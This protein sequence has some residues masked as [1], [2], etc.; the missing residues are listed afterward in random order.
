MHLILVSAQYDSCGTA[1]PYPHISS[2][3]CRA[4]SD[5]GIVP[6]LASCAPAEAQA[7]CTD[8]LLLTGG[9]DLTPEYYPY[10][11]PPETLSF[12]GRP[13]DYYEIA[14]LRAFLAREKPVFGIC[15]GMQLINVLLGGTLWED[16]A[17]ELGNR[18]HTGGQMHEIRIGPDSWL[19][20]R[21]GAQAVVN[22]YH[23]QACRE[24]AP[25]LTETARAPDGTTEA[26]CHESLPVYG[27][28]WHPERMFVPE[29]CDSG[30]MRRLFAF[31]CE[32]VQKHA[33]T[34]KTGT[35]FFEIPALQSNSGMV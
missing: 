9:G 1:M 13:R 21:F 5:V 30:G 7:A 23:H 24:L 12:S 17:L 6:V 32:I 14:L 3:Y 20:S 33:K 34:R 26:F 10:H 25:G 35:G 27:V 31:W 2:Y 29:E 19:F 28:Q 22:S 8:A 15:R 18:T 16:M 4:F 11:V